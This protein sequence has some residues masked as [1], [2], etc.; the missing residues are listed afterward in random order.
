MQPHFGSA[1][2][3]SKVDNVDRSPIRPDELE[4]NVKLLVTKTGCTIEEAKMALRREANNIMYSCMLISELQKAQLESENSLTRASN[5]SVDWGSEL[6]NLSA[7]INSDGL[8]DG[9]NNLEQ[10]S[11]PLGAD[12]VSDLMDRRADER[13]WGD[14][15]RQ[16]L[17]KKDGKWLPK[18][19][20][21]PVDDEPW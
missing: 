9:S 5:T 2:R 7:R 1:G 13:R 14:M 3:S 17:G 15:K 20:P 10:N 12:G 19:N 8:K 11:F 6:A 4:E 16:I 21:N 18:E